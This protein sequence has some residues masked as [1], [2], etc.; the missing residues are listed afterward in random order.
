M[1]KT[2]IE[3][4]SSTSLLWAVRRNRQRMLGLPHYL[5][6]GCRCSKSRKATRHVIAYCKITNHSYHARTKSSSTQQLYSIH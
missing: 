3:V 1:Q 5:D 2:T 6:L 4:R